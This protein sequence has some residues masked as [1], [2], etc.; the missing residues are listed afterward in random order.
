[1]F[2]RAVLIIILALA[3]LVGCA[4]KEEDTD[5]ASTA[6][7]EE[8]EE[9]VASGHGHKHSG[10]G[11]T[12]PAGGDEKPADEE[13]TVRRILS[14]LQEEDAD[15]LLPFLS[16][17]KAVE[18]PARENVDGG[19]LS[20]L[21]SVEKYQTEDLLQTLEN[22][23]GPARN[24]DGSSPPFDADSIVEEMLISGADYKYRTSMPL[25]RQGLL[26]LEAYTAEKED[27]TYLFLYVY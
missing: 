24:A 8:Q 17:I 14:V 25:E 15:A 21:A 12:S 22:I 13:E 16:S 18:V 20:A 27:I 11:G 26:T 10:E 5:I 6:V 19:H 4:K 23:F 9:V 3:V 1:M 7:S 2:Q